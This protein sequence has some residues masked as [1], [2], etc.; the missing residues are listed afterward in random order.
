MGKSHSGKR[1][2]AEEPGGA[3]EHGPPVRT[4]SG[5]LGGGSGASDDWQT[6]ARSWAAIAGIIKRYRA[7]QLWMP[8]YYDGQC[9]EHVRALGF[10]HVHHR[11]GEDFFIKAREAKFLK[12]IDLILDNPP[13][14]S[15][16]MKESVLRALASTGKPFIML[17]PMTVLHVGFVREI[18]DA[19]KIQVIIPRRVYVKKTN[20]DEV[21]F[22]YLCW[23]CYGVR[24]PR[25][26]ILI[27]DDQEE[28]R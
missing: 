8:F 1:G 11:P 12:S 18:L 22:K 17:L 27:D 15:P 4:I 23:F 25:D 3:S 10:S 13:Y 2:R 9:A 20:A 19:N 21:P 5:H 26:L 7:K 6:T 16:E 28:P 14:T 24:L